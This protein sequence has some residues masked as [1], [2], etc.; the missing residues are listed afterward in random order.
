M[1]AL[2]ENGNGST[3][4]FNANDAVSANDADVAVSALPINDPEKDDAETLPSTLSEPEMF[5]LP[6]TFSCLRALGE[7]SFIL[8]TQLTINKSYINSI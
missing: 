1:T 2:P 7:S 8:Y 6:D 5:A 3:P 4:A